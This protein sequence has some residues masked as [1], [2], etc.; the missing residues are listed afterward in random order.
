M[1]LPLRAAA[2]SCAPLGA[3]ELTV[4]Y[5]APAKMGAPATT[6]LESVPALQAGR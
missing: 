4:N 5:A 1:T 3:M 6:S 2:R